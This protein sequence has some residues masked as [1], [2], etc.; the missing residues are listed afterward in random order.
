MSEKWNDLCAKVGRATDRALAKAEAIAA[1]AAQKQKIRDN[2][3]KLERT[4]ARLGRLAYRQL[5]ANDT[6]IL[7]YAHAT[8]ALVDQID[9][10]K[11]ERAILRRELEAMN[12]ADAKEDAP[13]EK[14]PE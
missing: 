9:A 4:Y 5:K 7:Q 1:R 12:A 14:T 13:N 6:C 11:T 2:Q 3:K 10:L 8:A